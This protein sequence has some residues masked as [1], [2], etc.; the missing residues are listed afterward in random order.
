MKA[1]IKPRINLDD[2]TP[3]QDVI[4]LTTPFIIFIDPSS[5]CNF[6]CTFCPTGDRGLIKSIQRYQGLLDFDLYRKIID[7]LA[8]FSD[9]IKVLR[10]YKDGEPFLNK[11]LEE[12]VAYAK[13]SGNVPYIDTTT[14]GAFLKPER[15]QRMIEAG[16][17]KI[18]I[19]VDGMNDEQYKKFTKF[20]FNFS[21]F[22]ENVKWLYNHKEQCEIVIKIPGELINKTQQQD[23]FD[24]FGDYCDRIFIENFAPCWPEFDLEKRLGV[25]FDHGI[26]DQPVTNTD[27]CPY[28]FYSLSINSDGTASACFLDWARKLLVGDVRKQSLPEIWHSLTMN[29]LRIA[30]LEGRRMKHPVCS[31][32]GQLTHCLPDNIDGYRE[33]LILQMKTYLKGLA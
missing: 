29:E 12:M 22:V 32:C 13:Q 4:P 24:T 6:Q 9:K 25:T 27:T 26:Y 5:A 33:Q 7:D 16:L 15:V 10:L 3:L 21:E 1:T 2:R 14:N 30:N 20:D 31:H 23:F 18:N 11:H 8:L 17:D 28:L 19:S